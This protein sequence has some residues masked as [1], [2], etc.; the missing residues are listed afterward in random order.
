MYRGVYIKALFGS[1]GGSGPT[2]G[3]VSGLEPS[4]G[5]NRVLGCGERGRGKESWGGKGLRVGSRYPQR[6][7]RGGREVSELSAGGR[8]QEFG[9]QGN[10]SKKSPLPTRRGLGAQ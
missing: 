5:P 8:G 7:G 9:E 1:L 6:E 10:L 4:F 3:I 2:L